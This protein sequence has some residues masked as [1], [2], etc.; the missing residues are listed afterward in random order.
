MPSCDAATRPVVAN[1]VRCGGA[2]NFFLA[3]RCIS[4][5]WWVSSVILTAVADSGGGPGLWTRRV[6]LP[7]ATD[8][9]G[10]GD[11]G[12]GDRHRQPRAPGAGAARLSLGAR[13]A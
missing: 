5:E 9:L 2:R 6:G 12:R 4:K 3:L 1:I 7:R 8:R 13:P 10:R 11:G